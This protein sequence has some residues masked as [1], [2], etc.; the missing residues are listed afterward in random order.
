MIYIKNFH[1]DKQ[2]VITISAPFDILYALFTSKQK[3]FCH[4][5][6]FDSII[7]NGGCLSWIFYMHHLKIPDDGSY[8]WC[9]TMVSVNI[10]MENL[11]RSRQ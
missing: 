4:S 6:G 5:T 8:Y 10:L 2:A 9:S 1:T 7:R 11:Q 3:S